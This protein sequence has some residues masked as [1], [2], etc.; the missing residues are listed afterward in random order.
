MSK[1]AP[2]SSVN[3]N[4]VSQDE[5]SNSFMGK[6]LLWALSVGRY[7]VV[8]TELI[9]ILSFL[10]RFKL[11]RDR[12]DLNEEIARYK[13]IVLS[14]G[15]LEETIKDI[16]QRTDIV[17]QVNSGTLPSD[18]FSLLETTLPTDVKVAKVSY[19]DS[20][21]NIKATAL[22]PQGFALFINHLTRNELVDHI[23]IGTISS[24]N[25]DQSIEFDINVIL[26]NSQP[27]IKE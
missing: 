3:V 27:I 2:K 23:N 18:V 21:I 8:F 15:N 10:S 6:F 26:K 24:K 4:L 13:A 5:F 22:S 19:A 9:V 1:P 16:Q 25:Q 14:Y 20:A 17:K 7:I 12:T 11:D